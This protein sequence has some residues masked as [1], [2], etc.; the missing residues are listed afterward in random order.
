[1]SEAPPAGPRIPPWVW[2]LVV[3]AI[4]LL[5]GVALAALGPAPASPPG[6]HPGP[7]PAVPYRAPLFVSG[8]DLVLVVALIGVYVR[9]YSETHARFALGLLVVLFALFF[10]TVVASPAVFGALGYAPGNLGFFFLLGGFFEAVAF[11]VFL[12]LSLE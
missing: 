9:T 11:A 3:L 12:Y 8:L 7:A 4:G 1:M 2:V 6:P 10:E 5:A